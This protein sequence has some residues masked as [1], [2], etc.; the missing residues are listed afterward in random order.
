M[1]FFSEKS[2]RQAQEIIT[3]NDGA[4]RVLTFL[5]GLSIL[6]CH[7]NPLNHFWLSFLQTGSYLFFY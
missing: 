4:R 1:I 5:S 2:Q 3:K 7:Q 6:H